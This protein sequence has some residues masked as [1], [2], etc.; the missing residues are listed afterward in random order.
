MKPLKFKEANVTF[1]GKT[2][3]IGDLPAWRN[4][5]EVVSCWKMSW[6]ERFSALLF[7][8]LWIDIWAGGSQ[9][10]IAMTISKEYFMQVHKVHVFGR[11]VFTTCASDR[12][13]TLFNACSG[14]T[15]DNRFWGGLAI[16]L[17]KPRPV[18]NDPNGAWLLGKCLCVGWIK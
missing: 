8:K 1:V 18:K 15:A 6:R 2:P 12:T 3:D 16:L 17:T 9:P 4:E 11:L 14:E 7:G 13:T 10:P 5:G